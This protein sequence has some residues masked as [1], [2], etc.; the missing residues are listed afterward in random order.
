MKLKITIKNPL[1]KIDRSAVLRLTELL[2]KFCSDEYSLE[3]TQLDSFESI[4]V[5]F[6]GNDEITE[7][8][9]LV[10]DSSDTTDVIAVPYSATPAEPAS[11]EIFINADLAYTRGSS[12]QNTRDII[13]SSEADWSPAHELALY[14]A[15]GFDHLAG[16]E[17]HTDTGFKE[18]R[19]REISW[20]RKAQEQF[21]LEKIF[22]T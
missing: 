2:L 14:I 4:S 3:K 13:D 19:K 10:M 6:A 8:N 18:M 12:P 20:V 9:R 15:H 17:D 21:P 11:A 1:Q 5:L 16:A 22:K 7:V